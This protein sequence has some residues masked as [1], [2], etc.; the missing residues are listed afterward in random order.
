[1]RSSVTSGKTSKRAAQ[2]KIESKPKIES[3]IPTVEF[4][5]TH[6]L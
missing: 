4:K 3:Y 2:R 1:M 6:S 5:M